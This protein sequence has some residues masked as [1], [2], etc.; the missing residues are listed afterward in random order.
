MFDLKMFVIS[1]KTENEN[2]VRLK[3]LCVVKELCNAVVK[4]RMRPPSGY[5]ESDQN[6][7]SAHLADELLDMNIIISD[8]VKAPRKE[9]PGH[10]KKNK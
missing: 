5:I 9:M 6:Y 8:I 4:S 10:L 1:G 7:T 2:P 3:T